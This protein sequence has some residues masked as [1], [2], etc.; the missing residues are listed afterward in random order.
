MREDSADSYRHKKDTT[1]TQH[2]S[3]SPHEGGDYGGC[4]A[5]S[6]VVFPWE[7]RKG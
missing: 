5:G 2:F 1:L 6:L 7:G 4:Y 3:G